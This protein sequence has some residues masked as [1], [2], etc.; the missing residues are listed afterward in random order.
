MIQRELV[1]QKRVQVQL[2]R[3][4]RLD[5]ALHARDAE[6]RVPL[7]SVDHVKAAPV[8]A[9]HIYL[10]RPILMVARDHQTPPRPQQFRRQIKRPLQANRLD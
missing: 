2:S 6:R 9:L 5:S 4:H 1:S 8:P 3:R 10:S 7:V